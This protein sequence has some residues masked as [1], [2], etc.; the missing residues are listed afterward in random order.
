MISVSVIA[1]K[2]VK[3]LG[4]GING[5]RIKTE[6]YHARLRFGSNSRRMELLFKT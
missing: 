4:Q 1:R 3:K 5:L 6:K 2:Q